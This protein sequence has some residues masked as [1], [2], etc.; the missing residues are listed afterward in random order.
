MLLAECLAMVCLVAAS[1]CVAQAQQGKGAPAKASV[2]GRYEGTAK[3]KAGD[4]ITVSID[5]TEAEGAL[6]GTIKSSH[7]DFTITGGS[8]QGETVTLEFDAGGPGT[9]SL[10]MNEDR[11]VGTWTAGEDGGRLDVKRV[12]AQDAPQGK[13]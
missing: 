9:I 11:L 2:T 4:V 10:R 8:H 1:C 13:S 12:A 6:S 5:L 7:G 3:N